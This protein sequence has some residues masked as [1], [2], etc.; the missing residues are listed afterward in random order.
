M[1]K[2]NYFLS[3]WVL[4]LSAYLGWQLF[5][6]MPSQAIL[7]KESQANTYPF[8]LKLKPQSA[9]VRI[10]N[11][12]PR[13]TPGMPLPPENYHLQVSAKGYV[14]KTLWVK[15]SDHKRTH[16]ITLNAGE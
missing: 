6:P 9:K 16:A 10:L 5:D 3:I 11:I 12:K 4:T 1:I 8:T 13:Y 7:K 14:S 2:T 15:H